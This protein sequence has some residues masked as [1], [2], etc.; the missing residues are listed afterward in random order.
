MRSIGTGDSRAAM[1]G[2]HKPDEDEEI[3][4]SVF[5]PR[6]QHVVESLISWRK[7]DFHLSTSSR[8]YMAVLW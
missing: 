6:E 3:L 5:G 8:I 2:F 7:S 1:P 4:E